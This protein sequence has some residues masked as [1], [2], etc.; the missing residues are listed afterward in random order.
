MKKPQTDKKPAPAWLTA[1]ILIVD[2]DE[3]IR[4]IIR[5]VLVDLKFVNI[6][7]IESAK[8]ALLLMQGHTFDL[9]ITDVQMPGMNGLELVRRIRAGLTPAA[10]G[11]RTIVLT[12]FAN[13]EV[14][15][16]AMSLEVN[17]FLVKPIK[18]LS[19][20]KRSPRP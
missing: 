5:R 3:F 7:E 14:L 4:K 18:R 1:R 20:R 11:T 12:S 15:S 17:G 16:V 2:D 13:T 6:K 9:I 19:W 8:S 10:P